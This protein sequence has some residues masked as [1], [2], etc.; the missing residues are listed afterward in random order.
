VT[1]PVGSPGPGGR[2]EAGGWD[3]YVAS[4]ARLRRLPTAEAERRQAAAAAEADAVAA[5]EADA[6]AAAQAAA[7]EQV[8][9]WDAAT[10]RARRAVS[11]AE[12][13]LREQGVALPQ[14]DGS[15]PEVVSRDRA[16][17]L[18]RLAREEAA[19]D[20]ALTALDVAHRRAEA[21]AAGWRGASTGQVAVVA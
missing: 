18:E 4:V 13:S 3:A 8:R 17:L 10:G 15:R 1:G 5:A 21:R 14:D 11:D 19:L 16:R 20:E 7:E 6:V 2:P 12:A 9:G